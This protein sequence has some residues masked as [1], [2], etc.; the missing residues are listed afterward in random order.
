MVIVYYLLYKQTRPSQTYS[1]QQYTD[2]K[3]LFLERAVGLHI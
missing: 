3:A 1:K 2:L